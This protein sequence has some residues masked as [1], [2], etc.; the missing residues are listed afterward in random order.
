[1]KIYRALL[2]V[3]NGGAY[4]GSLEFLSQDSQPRLIPWPTGVEQMESEQELASA[5]PADLVIMNPPFTRG[6]FAA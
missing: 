2:G 5:E 6:Q 1:M 3:E 4:L